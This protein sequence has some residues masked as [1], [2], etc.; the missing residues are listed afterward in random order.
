M[1]KKPVSLM[2]LLGAPKK[3]AKLPMKSDRESSMKKLNKMAAEE[4][5]FRQEDDEEGEDWR[6]PD[7][8]TVVM[9]TMKKDGM[10]CP[11][12]GAEMVEDDDMEEADEE[13]GEDY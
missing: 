4:A 5:K 6:C 11:C 12:C 10:E 2:I 7:C 9:A 1:D 13:E 8:G 3:G